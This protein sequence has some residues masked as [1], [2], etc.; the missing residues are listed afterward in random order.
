MATAA[1]A[2]L[3]FASNRILVLPEYRK[4]TFY[5]SDSTAPGEGEVK[6]MD[7]I[8]RHVGHKDEVC[9]Q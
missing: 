9:T 5:I 4:V 7:W 3:N 6:L 1:K 2:C 8:I